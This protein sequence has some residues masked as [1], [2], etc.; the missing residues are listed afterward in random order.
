MIDYLQAAG[1]FAKAPWCG[2]RECEAR[3]KKE[4]SATIRCLPLGDEGKQPGACICCGRPA[5]AGAAWAQ[6]Y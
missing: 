2:R 5:V 3:V 1:G 4:S 6:A